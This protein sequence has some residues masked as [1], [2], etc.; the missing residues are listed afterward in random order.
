VTLAVFVD[1]A[2][3][4]QLDRDR[5]EEVQLLP[6]RTACDD[7][8]RVL[9]DTQVLHHAEARHV[10][11]RFQLGERAAV[12]LEEQVEQEATR[13]VGECLEHEVIVSHVPKDR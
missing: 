9:E 4:E 6:P 2:L 5:V 8:S 10:Q 12:T 7:E 1:P 3:V 13:W 11:L